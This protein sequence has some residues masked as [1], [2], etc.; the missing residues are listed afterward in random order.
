M[1]QTTTK[2]DEMG[3]ILLRKDL[4][5]QLN[6]KESDVMNLLLEKDYIIVKKA[7]PECLFC[8]AVE[9]LVLKNLRPICQ[10]CIKEIVNGNYEQ[11][12]PD[13]PK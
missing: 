11:K 12:C 7:V 9:N 4:R 6:I 1:L 3:R 2:V 10:D 13:I 5:K 8:G